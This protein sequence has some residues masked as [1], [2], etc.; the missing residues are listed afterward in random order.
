VVRRTAARESDSPARFLK[1]VYLLLS[2]LFLLFEQLLCGEDAPA[3][4]FEPLAKTSFGNQC[5][6][7]FSLHAPHELHSCSFA[8]MATQILRAPLMAPE[9]AQRSPHNCLIQ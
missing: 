3:F 9:A 2:I 4:C 1:A 8:A 6:A 5:A 7:H